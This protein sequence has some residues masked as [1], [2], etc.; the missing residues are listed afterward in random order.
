MGVCVRVLTIAY[1]TLALVPLQ[2]LQCVLVCFSFSLSCLSLSLVSFLFWSL[3]SVLR[4]LVV[5]L[6]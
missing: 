5:D 6:R 2:M 3:L 4:A 1:T